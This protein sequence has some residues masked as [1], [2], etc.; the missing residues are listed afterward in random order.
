MVRLVPVAALNAGPKDGFLTRNASAS[1]ETV[2]DLAMSPQTKSFALPESMRKCIDNRVA[3]GNHGN[4]SEHIRDLVRRDQEEQAKKPLRD[5]IE[6]G[7]ASGP[8]RR[9]SKADGKELLAIARGK[10]DRSRRFC[11][12]GRSESSSL[13]QGF[14]PGGSR[15]LRC[16][17]AF[18]KSG[19]T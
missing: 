14:G 7:L 1:P 16:S 11:A 3:T 18:S 13:F 10:I 5:L 15:S 17:G 4:T 6:E 19:S 9:R 2:Q 8:G 12:R